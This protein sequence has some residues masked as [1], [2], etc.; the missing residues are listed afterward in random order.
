MKIDEIWTI[1][2]SHIKYFSKSLIYQITVHKTCYHYTTGTRSYIILADDKRCLLNWTW[3]IIPLSIHQLLLWSLLINKPN[4]TQFIYHHAF[5]DLLSIT[6]FT[7]IIQLSHRSF[8]SLSQFWRLHKH[9]ITTKP[10]NILYSTNGKHSRAAT[11]TPIF[12]LITSC[13]LQTIKLYSC[14]Q[15]CTRNQAGKL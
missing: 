11:S 9:Q 10:F 3:C 1:L 12:L 4:I 15:S 6:T 7:P 2:Y 5:Y 14:I 8:L 13:I